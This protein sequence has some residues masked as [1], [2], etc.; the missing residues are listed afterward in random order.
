MLRQRCI[1]VAEFV[2]LSSIYFVLF[3][4]SCVENNTDFLSIAQEIFRTQ[5]TTLI[6]EISFQ[7]NL[8]SNKHNTSL[9]FH[10]VASFLSCQ[11]SNPYS[12]HLYCPNSHITF[13]LALSIQSSTFQNLTMQ[14]I[15]VRSKL[16]T[17]ELVLSQLPPCFPSTIN[18]QEALH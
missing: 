8:K 10:H 15:Q 14:S 16:L 3:A 1:L 18:N 4:S 11:Q 7:Q 17:A 5:I 12:S 6:L 13:T 9:P 2:A